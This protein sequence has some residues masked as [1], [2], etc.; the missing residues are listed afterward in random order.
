[1]PKRSPIYPKNADHRSKE[2]L[3][4]VVVVVIEGHFLP[5]AMA[6]EM[7]HVPLKRQQVIPPSSPNPYQK[8]PLLCQLK[9]LNLLGIR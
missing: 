9:S 8:P 6:M 7:P 2:R 5:D 3:V 4:V 1:M